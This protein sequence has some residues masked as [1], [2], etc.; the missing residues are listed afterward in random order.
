MN[1]FLKEALRDLALVGVLAACAAP[2]AKPAT[3]ALDACSDRQVGN[4]TG[5]IVLIEGKNFSCRDTNANYSW[6]LGTERDFGVDSGTL[7]RVVFIALCN[8]KPSEVKVSEDEMGDLII[9]DPDSKRPV[10]T[11]VVKF[12]STT[13]DVVIASSPDLGG[14]SYTKLVIGCRIYPAR[15]LSQTTRESIIVT[16]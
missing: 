6:A 1:R 3:V 2:A 12:S 11:S 9:F 5:K 14:Y 4:P 13:K 7:D 16:K 15:N 10:P 8:Q